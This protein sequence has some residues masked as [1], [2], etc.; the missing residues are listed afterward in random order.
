M[1]TTLSILTKCPLF[2]GIEKENLS[3]MLSCLQATPIKVEKNQ[4]ILSEGT[5]AKHV[6]ILLSGSA[7]IEQEDFYGNRSIVANII[8]GELFGESFACAS[9]STLPVNVIATQDSEIMLL[10]CQRLMTTCNHACEFHNKIIFNLLKIVATKNLIF[11]R[12]ITI[13]S[14][15][16]TREKLMAYLLSEAKTNRSNSFTIPFDRQELADY[17]GVERSGL[18]MEISKLRQEGVLECKKGN[19]TLL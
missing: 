1:N 3:G 7:R 16:S 5:P 4:Y 19:F 6:G 12:K 18:S 11:H 8:P 17:L 15:R 9:L 13:T 14:K 10:D 2:Q